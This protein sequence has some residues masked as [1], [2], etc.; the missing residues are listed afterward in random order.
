[1]GTANIRAPA[2]K[3][4][5]G[6]VVFWAAV[7]LLLASFTAQ[8]LVFALTNSQTFDEATYVASGYSYL[9]GRGFRLNPEH[10]P[11]AKELIALPVYLLYGLP[12]DPDPTLWRR[13]E[14][15]II[16]QHFLY[17]SPAPA[18][19]ILLVARLP[20]LFLGTLLVGLIGR[21]AYRLWGKGSA[22]VGMALAGLDPNLVAH[23]S[24]ATTDIPATFFM[25]LTLYLLWEYTGSPSLGLLVGVGISAGLALASKYSGLLA[26]GLIELLL[27]WP[28]LPGRL[29]PWREAHDGTKQQTRSGVVTAVLSALVVF[30]LTALVLDVAYRGEG[31]SSFYAGLRT[32]WAHRSSGHPAFFL[33]QYSREGW[34]LY[35][36]LAFL[37]K[38]P[39][40][41]LLAM[42]GSVLL[43]RTGRPFGRREVLLVLVPALLYFAAMMLARVNIGLRYVLPVYPLLFVAASR[44]ATVQFPRAW[45]GPALLAGGVAAT[46][47]SSLLTA[48]HQLAYFN[49]LVGGPRAGC[50]YL[51]DSNLDWGQ[52]L[53]GLKAYMEREGLPMIY[54]SYFGTAPPSGYGIRCQYAPG[55]SL[56]GPPPAD[57]LAHRG[58]REV[59]AISVVNLQGLYL[60]DRGLYRWLYSRTPVATIGYSIYVYDLKGDAEAHLRLAEAYLAARLDSFVEPELRRVLAIEP[61]NADA[62]RLLDVR[63]GD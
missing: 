25:A 62:L 52:D 54:L 53:K 20:N 37:I 58:E 4:G 51:S 40:G 24:L 46:G 15:W 61:S 18:D 19:R 50:R 36:P 60:N 42:A 22:L 5:L 49:E 11:L 56:T 29:L 13:A 7:L 31:F 28:V 63:R 48:P 45:L 33:G 10:L 55:Y 30:C 17:H 16:A 27:L 21:W 35:F 1:M 39:V 26:L 23:S 38:T 32:Q 12:F 43:L 57:L 41:S 34:W 9:S 44:L 3:K 6:P 59:L 8:G 14:Q 47:V 2:V